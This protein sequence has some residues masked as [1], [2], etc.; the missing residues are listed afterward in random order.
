MP[1]QVYSFTI[2]FLLSYAQDYYY[3]EQWGY[4]ILARDDVLLPSVWLLYGGHWMETKPKDYLI[5]FSDGTASFCIDP[6][7]YGS[8]WIL[9]DAFLRGWYSIHDHDQNRFGFVPHVNSTKHPAIMGQVPEVS[10]EVFFEDRPEVVVVDEDTGD[11]IYVEPAKQKPRDSKFGQK[12]EDDEDPSTKMKILIASISIL[13]ILFGFCLCCW[14]AVNDTAIHPHKP[15]A[16][17]R[18]PTASAFGNLKVIFI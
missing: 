18:Q 3:D 5:Y 14:Q 1:Q 15:P 9:G 13:V 12:A 7:D 8:Y 6:Q 2:A 10:Y 11:V 4:T 17:A 16:V